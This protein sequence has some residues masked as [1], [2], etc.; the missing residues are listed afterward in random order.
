MK[1]VGVSAAGGVAQATVDEIVDGYTKF[2]MHELHMNRFL[3][4]HNNKRFL[5]DRVK[6]VPGE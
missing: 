4:L 5:R 1:T 3:G 6:E 2:D